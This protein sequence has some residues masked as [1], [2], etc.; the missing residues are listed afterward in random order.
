MISN[1]EIPTLGKKKKGMTEKPIV[2]GFP[3]FKEMFETLQVLQLAVPLTAVRLTELTGAHANVWY[4]LRWLGLVDEN[5]N[6]STQMHEMVKSKARFRSHLK[7]ILKKKYFFV[8]QDRGIDLRI[9]CSD[10]IRTAFVNQ[11]CTPMQAALA[12]RFFILACEECDIEVHPDIKPKWPKSKP[13]SK[14]KAAKKSI[15][16][17][18]V[19]EE[20]ITPATEATTEP[21]KPAGMQNI[22]IP[23]RGYS[24]GIVSLPEGLDDAA[25]ESAVN[26]VCFL[27]RNYYNVKE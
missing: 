3:G 4:G 11:E 9:N 19:E 5:G 13:K 25:I 7:T 14:K 8:F 6:T 23:I 17:N 18:P 15:E 22:A 16:K 26:A 21:P 27:V 24:D 12:M 1:D 20:V 2:C 10:T